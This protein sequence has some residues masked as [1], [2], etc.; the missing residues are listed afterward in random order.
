MT[1]FDLEAP[2]P[3]AYMDPLSVTASIIAVLQLSSNVLSYMINIKHATKEQ[4]KL[5][6]EIRRC[7]TILLQLKDNS[8][9]S[10]SDGDNLEW[11]SK[12]KAIE[13]APLSRITSVLKEL[14]A[15]LKPEDGMKKVTAVLKW[16]F[17]KAEVAELTQ[18]M[19]REMQLLQLVLSVDTK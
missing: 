4:R 12:I 9:D 5:R 13:G 17:T 10:A 7:E 19:S 16:P 14:E 1:G 6:D 15:K 8:E 2:P 18:T 3:I 11:R